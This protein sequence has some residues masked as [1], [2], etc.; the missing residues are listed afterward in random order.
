MVNRLFYKTFLVLLL[1]LST[2]ARAQEISPPVIGRGGEVFPYPFKHFTYVQP[3]FNRESLNHGDYFNTYMIRTA[4]SFKGN[5][6]LRVDLPLVEAKETGKQVFGTSDVKI[7][8]LH[9]TPLPNQWYTGYGLEATLPTASDPLLGSGKWQARPELGLVRF[10]GNPTHIKGSF[11]LGVD[12]RFDFAG[13]SGRDHISVLGI[14]PN[15]DYWGNRWYIGYYATW[16]Y[17]FIH[18]IWDIPV[19][20]ECGYT[21]LPKLTLAI[22]WIQPLLKERTYNYQYTAKMRYMF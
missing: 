7:R 10:F 21:I 4:K 22:E 6:H 14:A 16:T 9:A 5:F 13:Q 2:Q 19:D 1:F 12:Y 15:I 18:K 11:L 8:L 3:I 20:V 17:D